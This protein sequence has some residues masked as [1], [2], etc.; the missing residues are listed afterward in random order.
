V[1]ERKIDWRV[2]VR[3]KR[4]R[5]LESSGEIVE[6]EGRLVRGVIFLLFL[7]CERK[8]IAATYSAEVVA[9]AAPV[10]LRWRTFIVT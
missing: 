4:E 6:R 9:I 10:E 5:E 2:I 8:E 1:A 3:R 7:R